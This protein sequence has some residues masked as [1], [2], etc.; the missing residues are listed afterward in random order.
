MAT[1]DLGT[2]HTCFNCGTK[3]YDLKKA[4][5]V[6]PKCGTDQRQT[7]PASKPARKAPVRLEAVAE[8]DEVD[9][10]ELEE[11]ESSDDEDDEG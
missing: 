6:C 5:P 1:Q 10:E 3:F 8:P 2:K 7:P 4:V 9:E 11:E